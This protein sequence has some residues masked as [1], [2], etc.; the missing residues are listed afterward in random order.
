MVTFARAQA[1]IPFPRS[2]GAEYDGAVEEQKAR[3]KALQDARFS[4]NG[5]ARGSVDR[6]YSITGES[7]AL[8]KQR[9]LDAAGPGRRLLE[10]GSG[11]GANAVELCRNGATVTG[12]DLSDVAVDL[13]RDRAG[14]E[15][16]S[17]V[18]FA[19]MDA[20]HMTFADDSF[21]V[22]CGGAILHHLR[23]EAAFP[24]LS[25]VM[26][27]GGRGIF[28][29]PLGY[30]PFINLYRK[31]TPQFRTPDEHPLLERDLS[32]ARDYFGTV[33]VQY[34]YLT[35]LLVLPLARAGLGR[36]LIAPANV[37]DRVLFR[38]LPFLRRYAWIM[39]IELRN[40]KKKSVTADMGIPRTEAAAP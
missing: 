5:G 21:D 12:I 10:I 28:L 16:I 23:L 40:P 9:V 25:R 17:S 37:V 20:E 3:E 11:A 1:V 4:T 36:G 8:F 14:A 32:L 31:L 13:A 35:T 34:F 27:P 29:E 22:I 33:S 18:S 39:V 6:M 24:E 15:G 38:A 30:N 19:A 26:A 2:S 7:H